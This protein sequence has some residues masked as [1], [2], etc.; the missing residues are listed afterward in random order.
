MV[1][2]S[3]CRDW[4]P[5]RRDLLTTGVVIS[6][7]TNLHDGTADEEDGASMVRSIVRSPA[8]PTP[9]PARLHA[10]SGQPRESV[11][12]GLHQLGLTDSRDALL[13]VPISYQPERPAPFVLSLHGA[14]GDAQGGLYPLYDLADQS[15]LIILAPPS[16]RQT[17]D[18]ILNSYGPDVAFIDAAL[19][20]AFAQCSVDPARC[21]IAGFSDGAS[22]ALS[23]GITNGDLFTAV[24]AFSPGFMAPTAQR[25][26]PR[27]FVSHGIQ[28]DVLPIDVTSRRIVPELERAGY[29]VRY[30]E[31][32]GPHTVPSDIAMEGLDWLLSESRSGTPTGAAQLESGGL[33]GQTQT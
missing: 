8:S 7:G 12:P 6:L 5:S 19:Q 21:G 17:W 26:S 31:F 13:Y 23:L 1:T 3:N 30:R 10:R 14:G 29:Q 32:D 33:N 20:R 24:L 18:V 2:V 22:Y 27:I 16:R 4:R 25:D 15:G 9:D 11:S 28:D